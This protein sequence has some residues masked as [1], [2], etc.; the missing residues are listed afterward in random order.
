MAEVT[1]EIRTDQ[2]WRALDQVA[3]PAFDELAAIELRGLPPGA[4]VGFGPVERYADDDGRVRLRPADE[5][6]LSCHL[7]YLPIRIGESEVGEV[8]IRPGKV[9]QRAYEALVSDLQTIWAGLVIG[10]GPTSIAAR[11]P[12]PRDLWATV[13]PTVRDLQSA[14]PT[15]LGLTG[16]WRAA[17]QVKR[18]GELNPSVLF[19]AL[20]GRPGRSVVV[21][22]VPDTAVLGFAA[23]TLTR[24]GAY[25]R[26]TSRDREVV[27]KITA[28]L[29]RPPFTDLPTLNPARD[30]PH[31]VKHDRR[32]QVLL[33]VRRELE[34]PE[35]VP[36]EGPGELR[37][38]IRGMDRLYE[39]WVFLKILLEARRRY[40]EPLGA[41]FERIATRLPGPLLRLDVPAGTSV[42]FP[43]GVVVA[44]EP[45]ISTDPR[46]SWE[47]LEFQPLTGDDAQALKPDVV[48]LRREEPLAVVIDAKYRVR[49]RIDAAAVEVHGKYARFRLEGRGIV[50]SVVVAHPHEG[51]E[52][53]Y[54]GYGARAFVPGGSRPR[55]PLPPVT[56]RDRHVSNVSG[57]TTSAVG[58][59]STGTSVGANPNSPDAQSP[60]PWP[61]DATVLVLADQW[62]M[63]RHL[64]SRR[65]DLRD[66]RQLAAGGHRSVAWMIAPDIP[67][68]ESFIGA[69]RRLGWEV[70]TTATVNRWEQLEQAGSLART[71]AAVCVISGDHAFI[72][73]VEAACPDRVRV[74]DDLRSL[75]AR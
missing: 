58:A 72:S 35:A 24:L 50:H 66:L 25:A 45:T 8:M 51:Y 60:P 4:V 41:G 30:V 57:S 18:P 16:G 37:L 56:K 46:R 73:A 75:P 68:L 63:H 14:T 23:D 55:V 62:W 31:R 9:S 71:A 32:L 65:I 44:F 42:E 27:A 54:A 5:D 1:V 28:V 59:Q 48:I 13:A 40:G 70:R 52:F 61:P 3:V 15:R 67:Q 20:R 19:A 69:A 43:G 53:S 22:A 38:G 26:N 2:G 17:H 7:G 6:E 47:G 33:R 21:D 39:Y 36:V 11:G 64:G 10:S 49:H 29:S 34:R 12:A 74:I